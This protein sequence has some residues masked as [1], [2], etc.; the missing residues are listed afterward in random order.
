MRKR[1]GECFRDL[2]FGSNCI[3]SQKRSSQMWQRFQRLTWTERCLLLE[4]MFALTRARLVLTCFPFRRIAVHAGTIGLESAL[5]I[6]PQQGEVARRI[7][8][9]IQA[10]ARRVPWAR[11][12]LAQ[13]LAAQWMTQRRKIPGTLYLGVAKD[14]EGPFTAHAWLRCGT[15]C[16]T[17]GSQRESFQILTRFGRDEL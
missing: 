6:S 3:H 11:Q 1:T 13:A 17:G 9:A 7:S 15:I 16:V 4:A 10:V 8:W 2:T 12:C 14:S 5:F